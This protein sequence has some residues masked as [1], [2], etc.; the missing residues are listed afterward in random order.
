MFDGADILYSYLG[1]HGDIVPAGT[2]A[3]RH[4]IRYVN[5][6]L[7]YD[8]DSTPHNIDLLLQNLSSY[9]PYDASLNVL[10]GKFA[11]VNLACNHAVNLRVKTLLSCSTGSSC[12]LCDDP[13]LTSTEKQDC[14]A[15]GCACF[16][17]TVTTE[18]EC[19]GANKEAKRVAYDCAQ[20][21][22]QTVLPTGTI[23]VMT[24]YDFDQGPGGDY[25]E[26]LTVPG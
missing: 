14:Y 13:L 6:G 3:G 7:F 11:H 26:Q 17:T 10:S 20:L 9:Q 22:Q 15:A 19:S 23:V 16:G 8:T 25:I 21:D 1:G 4:G 12:K 18:S 2:S 24:I 5:V